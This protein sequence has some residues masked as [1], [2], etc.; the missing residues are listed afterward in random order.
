VTD[1]FDSDPIARELRAS[2]DRHAR[3][4]PRG[5]MLAERIIRTSDASATR[6]WRSGWRTWTLPLIA[7]GAVA[8]V[9]AVVA[10][11]ENFQS[12]ASGPHQPGNSNSASVLQSTGPSAGP[13]EQS[14]AILSAP[15]RHVK[16]LDVTF[17]SE[18]EG[19]ALA[20]ADCVRGT[21]RCAALF[22]TANG[23]KWWS[24]ANSTPFNVAGVAAG[25]TTR[26]VTNIRFAT[27]KVGYA[28]GPS[29]FL[30]TTDGGSHW[31]L[32]DGGAIALESLDNNV[33]RVIASS[34]SGCPGPCNVQVETAAIGSSN[35]ALSDLAPQS[36]A[37]IGF[38]RGKP[39]N[40]Y[41]LVQRNP[42]GGA[43]D[44][45]STLYRSTD[46]GV[47]WTAAGEP[48]PQIGGAVDS[49]AIAAGGDNVVSALCF[50][51]QA[52]ARW[53]VATSTNG[54]VSFSATSGHVPRAT[55]RLLTGDPSTVL[56]TADHG[57][58]RSAD[59]GRTWHAVPSV[60]GPVGFVGFESDTVGRAVSADGTTIWTTRNGGA[61]WTPMHFG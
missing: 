59:G 42:A 10:G 30:M 48:C 14:T 31:A 27:P 57:L 29:A 18:N 28:Y 56:V 23:S 45:T 60:T 37:T 4:A 41:L 55:A 20:S 17:G 44:A 52:A 26:C 36:G 50:V 47:H 46:D 13:T 58:T 32:K 6:R 38:S 21:G 22:H 49:I 51:R 1:N 19:W 12:N 2:L 33:I 53:F 35:W 54:G 3:E 7:A 25:C 5:D 39:S 8:G 9:V 15:L 11:I 34:D 24:M 16:I 61:T 43:N 40:A